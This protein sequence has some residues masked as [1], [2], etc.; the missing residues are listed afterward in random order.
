MAEASMSDESNLIWGGDSGF[1]GAS[2]EGASHE[3]ARPGADGTTA[4]ESLH[5]RLEAAVERAL[6]DLAAEEQWC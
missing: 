4:D 1:S 3:G 6:N 5:H 2:H